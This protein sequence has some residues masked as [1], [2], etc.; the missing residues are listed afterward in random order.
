MKCK[1]AIRAL[2]AGNAMFCIV[3]FYFPFPRFFTTEQMRS[4]SYAFADLAMLFP[5][6]VLLTGSACLFVYRKRMDRIRLDLIL[7]FLAIPL[8]IFLMTKV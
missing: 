6:G 5:F 2:L 7:A 8:D 1:F 3:G 4:M